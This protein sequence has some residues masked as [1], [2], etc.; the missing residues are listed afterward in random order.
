MSYS[1]NINT[2]S[3]STNLPIFPS[4]ILN[5]SSSSS[6]CPYTLNLPISLSE[7]FIVNLKYVVSPVLD[8][9]PLLLIHLL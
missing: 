3:G 1:L 6:V 9:H 2:S 7:T 4:S 5:L 8:N